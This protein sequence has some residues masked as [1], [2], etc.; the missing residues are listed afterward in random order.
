MRCLSVQAGNFS[1]S[2]GLD[3]VELRFDFRPDF[4]TGG[5]T[6]YG[7]SL[8]RVEISDR[9]KAPIGVLSDPAM[10]RVDSPLKASL[11]VRRLRILSTFLRDMPQDGDMDRQSPY[12]KLGTDDGIDVAIAR[13][14]V[15]LS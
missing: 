5:T 6:G 4:V 2:G 11:N 7:N 15:R 13:S 1:S 10:D 14:E 9:N 3:H 8:H 12:T